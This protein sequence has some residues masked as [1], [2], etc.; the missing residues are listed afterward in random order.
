MKIEELAS[1]CLNCKTKPC[2][3]GCLLGNNIPDVI[4]FVK[5]DEEGRVLADLSKTRNTL[6]NNELEYNE[7]GNVVAKKVVR[8]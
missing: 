7:K 2:T 3:K 1:Y 4:N 8:M 5:Y 6:L